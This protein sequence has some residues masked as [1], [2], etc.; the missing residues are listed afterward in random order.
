MKDH[1]LEACATEARG[2]G[3]LGE[4]RDDLERRNRQGGRDR[5]GSD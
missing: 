1:G 5:A 3:I 4:S 2:A